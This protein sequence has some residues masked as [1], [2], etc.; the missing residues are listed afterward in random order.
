MYQSRQR[1]VKSNVS[2]ECAAFASKGNLAVKEIRDIAF[3]QTRLK[4]WQAILLRRKR[5]DS[6]INRKRT[7]VH[8][9]TLRQ[10]ILLMYCL[11][12]ERKRV[13]VIEGC[14][15][16]VERRNSRVAPWKRCIIQHNVA[17]RRRIY[18]LTFYR[19]LYLTVHLSK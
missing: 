6:F 10:V 9:T 15:H 12:L 19:S 13:V 11:E 7:H 4:F 14:G 1:R 8:R 3:H 5:I 16:V 2:I 17:Y 18:I